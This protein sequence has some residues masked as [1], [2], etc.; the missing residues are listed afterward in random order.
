MSLQHCFV[1]DQF[2][3]FSLASYTSKKGGIMF[4]IITASHSLSPFVAIMVS[5][6]LLIFDA[7]SSLPLSRIIPQVCDARISG[8]E[9]K[10]YTSLKFLPLLSSNDQV[11]FAK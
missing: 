3:F 6:S 1:Y 2:F 11:Q 8:E 9:G 7:P 5:G 10:K 4:G